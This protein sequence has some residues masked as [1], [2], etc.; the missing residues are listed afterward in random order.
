MDWMEVKNLSRFIRFCLFIQLVQTVCCFVMFAFISLPQTPSN[1][2][3]H[4]HVLLK[5]KLQNVIYNDVN[6]GMTFNSA[7]VIGVNT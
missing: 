6:S 1:L 5:Q 2:L 7:S 4:Q 3:A